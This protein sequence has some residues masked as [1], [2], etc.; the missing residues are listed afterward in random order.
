MTFSIVLL[1]I[2]IAVAVFVLIHDSSEDARFEGDKLGY[3][4]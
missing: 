3:R 4:S 2:Q 1:A